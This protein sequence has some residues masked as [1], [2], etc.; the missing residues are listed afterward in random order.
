MLLDMGGALLGS[1]AFAA[2]LLAPGFVV[3]WVLEV[4]E[5]RRRSLLEQL[6]W[7][8][9]L[10]LGV[11]TVAIVGL[12]RVVGVEG[13]GVVLMG[14]VTWAGW[15]RYRGRQRVPLKWIAL[16]GVWALVVVA[17]LVDVGIGGRLWM[18]VTVYDHSVRTAIVDAVMRTGVVPVDP[19]YWPGHDVAL[20]YYY[21]W[22][23][24]CA[25]VGKIAHIS[26]RQAFMASCVWPGIAV[27]AMLGLYGKYV[28][29]W[30][31]G[32]LRWRMKLAVGLLAVTGLDGLVTLFNWMAG[33]A[34]PGDMEWWSIDQVTSWADAFLWV[35]HHVAA[36]VCCLLSW[37]LLWMA[38]SEGVERRRLMLGAMAGVSFASTFGLSIY[39]AIGFGLVMV[40]WL[41][42]VVAIERMMGVRMLWRGVA[43]AV[44]TAVVV[45]MPYVGSLL[46]GGAAGVG[47]GEGAGRVVSFGVRQMLDPEM[48]GRHGF[49]GTQI[50]AAVLMAPGYLIEFG[51]FG[52]A[53]F[54]V[55]RTRGKSEGERA[56]VFLFFAGLGAASF[57]RSTVIATNDYGV[58]VTLLAQFFVVLLAVRVWESARGWWRHALVGLAVIGVGG[59]VYQV[60][61]LRVYLPWQQAHGNVAMRELA[62]QNA[63]LREAYAQLDGRVPPDARL[64]YAP[65]AGDGSHFANFP[66]MM[67]AGRQLVNAEASCSIGF[68]GEPGPCAGMWHDITTLFVLRPQVVPA[69]AQAAALC[70]DMGAE[71]LVVTRWDAVWGNGASWVWQLPAVVATPNVRIVR[72]GGGLLLGPD[73]R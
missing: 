40:A 56:L 19:F 14:V 10:S 49:A 45:L 73:S 38:R 35:P 53:M 43:V 61:A 25:V 26:A 27:V 39:L 41:V 8:V 68:G 29:G 5:F 34:T 62:E 32:V 9:V 55:L 59:T 33:G 12:V 70:D 66:R 54:V 31:G 67:S 69:A 17:S 21:F 11:G 28:L 16:A 57:L 30:Q 64:Q 13:A 37:L 36:L 22:Y 65:L 50:A 23:V 71:Y 60:V 63:A 46:R 47:G 42:R 24:T 15:L 4:G 48:L 3:G 72:C 52:L 18:S 2:A 1:L 20:R 7:S 44:A 6:A 58:R 51:F